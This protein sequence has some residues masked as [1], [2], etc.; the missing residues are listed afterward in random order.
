LVV[1]LGGALGYIA[2]L[3]GL[4]PEAVVAPILI[5]IGLEITAQT[6]AATPKAHHPAVAIAFI[7]VIANL[8]LI[9]TNAVLG[10]LGLQASALR[11]EFGTTH[12]AILLLGNGFIVTALV[13]AGAL[14]FIIDGHLRRAAALMAVGGIAALFGVMHSPYDNGRLFLPWLADTP[15]PWMLC[16][17]YAAVSGWFF[18]MA[19][20][21]TSRDHSD[22]ES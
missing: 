21:P 11:G 16:A 8:V 1:G 18:L 10:N 15:T 17:A 20:R 2:V 12:H 19:A 22:H 3:A 5:F 14:A 13:W 6:F 7:P 4:I 9:Q